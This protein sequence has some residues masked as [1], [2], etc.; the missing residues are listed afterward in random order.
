MKRYFLLPILTLSLVIFLSGCKLNP[1]SKE[2]TRN[3]ETQTSSKTGE[4]T[5][6]APVLSLEG[7]QDKYKS[8]NLGEIIMTYDYKNYILVKYMNENS[9][10]CFDL[11]NLNT[12]D[13]DVLVEG[14]EADI[15]SFASGDRI[16]LKSNG[17]N[18]FSGQKDFPYYMVFTRVEE[19]KGSIHDFKM[20]KRRLL[21]GIN[22]EEEFGVK[23]DGMLQDLK[24]TLTGFEMEF[25][26]QKGKEMEFYA[27]NVTIQA[28][29]TS[30][31]STK[32]QFL[33]ELINT[34]ISPDLK[35]KIEEQNRYIKSIEV[36]EMGLNSLIIV[37]LKDICKFYTAELEQDKFPR[38][39]FIFEES[40]GF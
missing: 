37:N 24:V 39:R 23:R 29:K 30:Y 4:A 18:Q 5:K 31:N 33:I 10:Q 26:P 9:R 7:I 17:F 22:E 34:T 14:I 19:I 16:E 11:Y 38:T 3:V 27:G 25:G 15:F 13:R 28:M 36:K 12:G 2:S 32:N 35:K 8:E 1:F 20:G 40:V 21:K 6:D